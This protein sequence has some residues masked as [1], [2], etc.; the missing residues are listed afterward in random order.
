MPLEPAPSP[1]EWLVLLEIRCYRGEDMYELELSHLDA[2]GTHQHHQAPRPE[3]FQ[4]DQPEKLSQ[5][6]NA[7]HRKLTPQAPNTRGLTAAEDFGRLPEDFVGSLL[8]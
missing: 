3:P 4:S 1:K 6:M 5:I 7:W 2:T 8:A